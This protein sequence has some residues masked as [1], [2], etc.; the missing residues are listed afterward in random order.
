MEGILQSHSYSRSPL[1]SFGDPE[2]DERLCYDEHSHKGMH[3]NVFK[4]CARFVVFENY[5]TTL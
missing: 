2:V 1:R 4:R 3:M 5:F